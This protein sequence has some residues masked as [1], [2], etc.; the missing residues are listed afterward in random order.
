MMND[1]STSSDEDEGSYDEAGI[2]GSKTKSPKAK[3][4][5]Q[6]K[7]N[8]QK[9]PGKKGSTTTDNKHKKKHS[10]TTGN[11]KAP[12]NKGGPKMSLN[13]VAKKVLEDSETPETSLV[14]ALLGAC[15]PVDGVSNAVAGSRSTSLAVVKERQA[16]PNTMYTT[17][18]EAIARR[19]VQQSPVP[20]KLHIQ[21]LN[22]VFRSVGGSFETNLDFD[23]DLESLDDSE[24]NSVLTEVVMAMA[25]T[26]DDCTLLCANPAGPLAGVVSSKLVTRGQ[27]EY[28]SI[29]EEFWFRL[30]DV[31]LTGTATSS[32][33]NAGGSSRKLAKKDDDDSGGSSDND[34]DDG[35]SQTP[36]SSSR[37]DLELVRDLLVRLTEVTPVGQPD[38]RMGA[39]IAVLQLSLACLERSVDLEAKMEAATR[40]YAAAS[41]ANMRSRMQGLKVTM[42]GWKR[43]KVDLEAMVQGVFTG[44]LMHRYRDSDPYIRIFS[45]QSLSKMCLLRPDLFLVDKFLKYFAWMCS[46]KDAGVRVAGLSALLAPFQEVKKEIGTTLSGTKRLASLQIDLSCMHNACIKFLPRIVDC[47]LD[48]QSVR[49]QEVAVELMLTMLRNI[50]LDDWEDADGWEQVNLKALDSK[51][52]PKVRRDALYFIVEQLDSFSDIDLSPSEDTQVQRLDSLA[53][54]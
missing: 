37:F 32:N 38:L 21:L 26:D 10:T 49:V 47:T 15:N 4:P 35:A 19:L 5:L 53:S 42:E 36:Y 28:R 33:G 30:G 23:A 11:S 44:V 1:S 24:W 48:S 52:S 13:Y 29:Y 34:D 17:Q 40:Q 18:L 2:T 8:R 6:P 50:F 43:Q 39:V 25:E 3:S 54:W 46:D 20:M 9:L 22:L 12:Q 16:M 14:A 7:M 27:Q 41:K 31:I 45:L 51:T